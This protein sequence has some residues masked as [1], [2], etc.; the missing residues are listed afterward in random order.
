M[1]NLK[2]ILW[3]IGTLVSIL[4]TAIGFLIPLVKNKKA[5]KALVIAGKIASFLQGACADAE[6]F[7]NYTGAEKK[8]YVMTQAK[9]WALANHIDFNEQQVSDMIENIITLSKSINKRDKD[10]EELE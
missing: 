4:G 1:E 2:D 5:K 7:V 6:K 10:K 3:C 9:E 8:Q